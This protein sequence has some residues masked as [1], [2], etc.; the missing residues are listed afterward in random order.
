VTALEEERE[1]LSRTMAIQK[2]MLNSLNVFMAITAKQAIDGYM[3][4]EE[5]EVALMTWIE[6]NDDE[7][8]H[9]YMAYPYSRYCDRCGKERTIHRYEYDWSRQ[10]APFGPLPPVKAVPR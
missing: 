8:D 1:H 4:K 7:V 6:L 3:T 10:V 5:S 9:A 2:G